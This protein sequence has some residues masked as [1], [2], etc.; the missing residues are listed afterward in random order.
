MK[1]LC[2]L[3]VASMLKQHDFGVGHDFNLYD[4]E[5]DAALPLLSL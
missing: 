5:P 1:E 3:T 4:T 2:H